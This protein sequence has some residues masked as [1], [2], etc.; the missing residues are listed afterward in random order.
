MNNAKL[1]RATKIQEAIRCILY[2]DWDPI[3]VRG[4]APDGEY[5]SY[6][7]GVYRILANSR[8]EIELLNS[9]THIE[10]D[11]MGF[12]PPRHEG[13]ESVVT[14]LLALDVTLQRSP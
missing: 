7:G 13:L 8:L 4:R 1:K 9:L 10:V 2:N 6:I 11:F 12:H 14:K 3:G 5:D